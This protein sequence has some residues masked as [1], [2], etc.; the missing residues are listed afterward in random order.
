MALTACR[1]TAG[2]RH[3]VLRQKRLVEFVLHTFGN[4]VSVSAPRA[5]RLR[6]HGSIASGDVVLVNEY[7]MVGHTYAAE[8]W[9]A[10]SVHGEHMVLV[11]IYDHRLPYGQG[12]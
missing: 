1:A 9:A 12:T 11:S 5:A 8:V 7:A 10:L 4:D 2:R 3:L 6:L